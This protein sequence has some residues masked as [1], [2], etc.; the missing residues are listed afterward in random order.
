MSTVPQSSPIAITARDEGDRLVLRIPSRRRRPSAYAVLALDPW[1][2]VGVIHCS[3]TAASYGMRC[4]HLRLA[5]RLVPLLA[6]WCIRRDQ[7]EGALAEG[8]RDDAKAALLQ[9]DW[10]DY[11]V[12]KLGV[13]V[14]WEVAR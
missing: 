10:L 13:R 2:R 14:T 3:C 11:Q 7:Y 5:E 9:R 6:E 1:G 12:R 8:F 4:W